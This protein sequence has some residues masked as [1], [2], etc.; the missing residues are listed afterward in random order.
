[1][2]LTFPT[3][4]DRL[5]GAASASLATFAQGTIVGSLYPTSSAAVQ[6]IFTMHN[7]VTVGILLRIPTTLRLAGVVLRGTSNVDV[8]AAN[9][10]IVLNEWNDI[11]FSWDAASTTNTDQHMYRGSP[12][13]QIAEA[14]YSATRNAG[15][16]TV[17]D[18][19]AYTPRVGATATATT[20]F[21]NGRI[22]WLQL[23]NRQLTLAEIQSIQFKPRALAGCKAWWSLGLHG[24]A[25]AVD[26]SGNGNTLTA[27]GTPTLGD[28]RPRPF[29][30][31][32]GMAVPYTAAVVTPPASGR[33]SPRQ[34]RRR[35]AFIAHYG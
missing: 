15:S 4:G 19:S 6:T 5:T 2:A 10:T 16:G 30:F 23:Y 7:G 33:L 13:V 12:T 14:S 32:R 11:A 24:V 8:E 28:N 27:T 29:L 9:S 1:M 25:T 31:G 26:F 34:N 35:R 3:T 22:G 20:P 18:F 17:Q 21:L